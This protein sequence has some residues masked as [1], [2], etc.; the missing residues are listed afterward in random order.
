[1]VYYNVIKI[2]TGTNDDPYRPDVPNISWVGCDCGDMFLVGTDAAIMGLVPLTDSE[3]QNYC[4]LN[5]ISYS[6]VTTQWAVS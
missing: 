1:M 5:D 2:G 6:D 3:L 4:T